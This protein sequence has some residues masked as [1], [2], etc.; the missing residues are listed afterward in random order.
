MCL[1]SNFI[2]ERLSVQSCL[3]RGQ[4]RALAVSA[5]STEQPLEVAPERGP[6]SLRHS[7]C[8]PTSTLLLPSALTLPPLS[9]APRAHLHVEGTDE[10]KQTLNNDLPKDK[11]QNVSSRWGKNELDRQWRKVSPKG[12]TAE[13]SRLG[14]S[15]HSPA[16]GLGPR[17]P[18][19]AAAL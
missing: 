8:S 14:P 12:A 5:R 7:V 4:Q 17:S 13:A 18:R 19:S 11:V 1:R 16:R 3:N 10:F 9:R 2:A 6:L 15:A